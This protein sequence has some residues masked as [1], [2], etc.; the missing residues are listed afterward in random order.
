[1]VS[2][3][4]NGGTGKVCMHMNNLKQ[5]KLSGLGLESKKTL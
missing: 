5:Q 1:M 2:P 4:E 3:A